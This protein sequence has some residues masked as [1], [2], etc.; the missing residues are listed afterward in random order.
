MVRLMKETPDFRIA[1]QRHLGE[2]LEHLELTDVLTW[3]WDYDHAQSRAIYWIAL[4]DSDRQRFDTRSAERL[5]SDL[6]NELGIIWEPVPHPGG[7]DQLKAT[8][9]QMA[10]RETRSD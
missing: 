1:R 2:M 5:A 6:C 3:E 7:A 8:L 9:Q 4:G 10:E